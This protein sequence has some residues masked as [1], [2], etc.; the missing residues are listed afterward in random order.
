MSTDP[1]VLSAQARAIAE[2]LHK[3]DD[4][5]IRLK[6]NQSGFAEDALDEIEIEDPGHFRAE[7]KLLTLNLDKLVGKAKRA[8]LRSLATVE[9][10]RQVPVLA[11][12]L[13]HESAHARFSLWDDLPETI[14]NPEYDP[15]FIPGV[16]TPKKADDPRYL[17]G[18]SAAHDAMTDEEWFEDKGPGKHIKPDIRTIESFPVSGNG[19]LMALASDLEEPRV[20]RLGKSHFSKT[21]KRAM[22]LSSGHLVLEQVA[23]MDNDE[24]NP[25]DAAASLIVLVGGR[26]SAGTLGNTSEGRAAVKKVLDSAQ[27]II[28]ESL[29]GVEGAHEDPYFAIM[30]I[31]SKATF[32]DNHDDA[33]PHLEA[34]RQIIN[35]IH[36]D[37]QDDPDTDPNG[38]SEGE[39][40][41]EG[42]GEGGGGAAVSGTLAEMANALKDAV[43]ALADQMQDEVQMEIENPDTNS[44]GGHGAVKFQ[45]PKAPQ[46]DRYENPNA[47]DRALYKLASAWMQSQIDPV[48]EDYEVNQWL[49]TGGARLD[50]R[51]FVR[52]NLAGHVAN[53]RADWSRETQI[54]K[55][56][57]PVKFATMLDG[58]GSMHAMARPSASI[59]WAAANAAADLPEARTASVVY[60][61][62][63]ALT[64]AP[65]HAAPKQLAISRTN[66]G[67][68]NFSDA[69][70]IIEKALWLDEQ[71]ED[72][73]RTNVVILIVSDLCYGGHG[74]GEAFNRITKDWKERGFRTL[75]VGS[76][77]YPSVSKDGRGPGYGGL[78]TDHVELVSPTEL[79]K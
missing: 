35:I 74:Q 58:S 42:G 10:F 47:D 37:Q 24:K 17:P 29:R 26:L 22:E 55:P 78:T 28:E 66:G 54:T 75:V 20:E 19:R 44:G 16:S 77:A 67:W 50:V 1:I 68:E 46:I 8:S 31:V 70:E 76:H 57:P 18:I 52:D 48:V 45:N 63:A 7:K 38:N 30:E 62:A 60:G 2:T 6:T 4:V 49:P 21:W 79:F 11:G 71:I 43:D 33:V 14:P 12:V 5:V 41:G 72:E 23:E 27:K 51:A 56:Q 34:A 36:P 9:D 65:G 13:A 40:E 53:Q 61:E 3:R 69:A 25:V 15:T 39:G 64:Q 59:A 73:Q 32:D